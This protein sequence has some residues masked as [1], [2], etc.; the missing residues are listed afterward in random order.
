MAGPKME[1][2]GVACTTT[3]P[4]IVTAP[5]AASAALLYMRKPLRGTGGTRGEIIFIISAGRIDLL[6]FSPTGLRT[7]L[8]YTTTQNI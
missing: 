2:R 3:A 6:F 8:S 5:P 1:D 4:V 7:G